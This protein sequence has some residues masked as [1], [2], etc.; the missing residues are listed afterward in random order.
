MLGRLINVVAATFYKT[1]WTHPFPRADLSKPL[2]V[3]IK[4]WKVYKGD[5]VQ[6]RT[7]NDRG[8]L[9]KI[10]RVFRKT[11][12]VIVKGV[13]KQEQTKSNRNLI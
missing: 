5:V 7:G 10:L 8:K 12:S 4:R 3:P 13:N 11:N 6:V 1:K 2:Q 9:G